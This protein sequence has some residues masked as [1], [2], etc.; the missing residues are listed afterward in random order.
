LDS[1]SKAPEVQPYLNRLRFSHDKET[2]RTAV[3]TTSFARAIGRG[4]ARLS[5]GTVITFLT[6]DR[7]DLAEREIM[8]RE[9]EG[10]TLLSR[11]TDE[12]DAEKRRPE[13]VQLPRAA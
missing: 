1:A 4:R 9:T 2:R 13:P 6:T 5:V 10:L 3:P 11:E 8:R 12:R 7:A